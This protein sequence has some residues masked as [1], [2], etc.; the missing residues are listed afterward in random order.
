[1]GFSVLTS[2]VLLDVLV[3]E[4]WLACQGV[5][6]VDLIKSF[7]SIRPTRGRVLK[8]EE[9]LEKLRYFKLSRG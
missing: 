6:Q 2:W 4:N 9:K 1:M 3:R 5:A 8:G 7:S